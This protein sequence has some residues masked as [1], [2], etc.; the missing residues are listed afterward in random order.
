MKRLKTHD[1]GRSP[2]QQIH[3][4]YWTCVVPTLIVVLMLTLSATGQQPPDKPITP[5]KQ[6]EIIDSVTR[7]L[8]EIYVFPD[9]AKN[10]EKHVRKLYKAKRYANITSTREFGD[11]LTADLLSI[12]HDK[13]LG[14]RFV[15]DEMIAQL[16]ND[17]L[18][19]EGRRRELKQL[20]RANYYFKELKILDGNIGY[21]KFN[22]FA[23]AAEA[24]AT[25]IAAMNFLAYTDAIII[26]LRENGGGEPSMIQLITSYFVKEPT[27]LNSFYIRRTDSTDQFWTQA[28]V[29]GPRMTETD[30]YVLTSNYTFSGAEEFTYNLKNMKRATIIGETTGGGAHPVD[31]HLYANLN[32]GIR[33]P[34]GRAVNPITHTNWEGTGVAPD[35]AV[36]QNKALTTAHMEALKK[37]R[38]RSTDEEAKAGLA[39]AID[40]LRASLNPVTVDLA[41]LQKYAGKYGPRT[42]TLENGGLFYQREGRPKYKMSPMS[43]DTFSLDELNNFRLKFVTNSSGVVT[44][45]VG[46]YDDGHTD[47]SP[48]TSN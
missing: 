20:Q 31:L 19:D 43:N 28:W 6:A 35:I 23:G 9:V 10:M 29:P 33:I 30:L 11:T 38:D 26:D 15:S 34:F 17:T 8:N 37:L 48:R 7:T 4:R 36:P 12:C 41:L 42:I 47:V 40:G 24:G 25:A 18:I 22:Q 27:H 39:W 2:W 46:S 5:A 1:L 3:Y 16:S 13:H 21:L 45:V 32:F 14:V 44:E